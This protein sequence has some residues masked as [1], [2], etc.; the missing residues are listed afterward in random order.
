MPPVRPTE[1]LKE[2]P[3]EHPVLETLG[4]AALLALVAVAAGELPQVLGKA[5]GPALP[6]AVSLGACAAFAVARAWP[7]SRA[8]RPILGRS[9]P[10]AAAAI[11]SIALV[12]LSNVPVQRARAPFVAAALGAVSLALALFRPSQRLLGGVRTKTLRTA[13]LGALAVAAVWFGGTAIVR[14]SAAERAPALHPAA[15]F[16]L[17]LITVDTLRADA[18]GC[19]GAARETSPAIDAFA[20]EGAR[21]ARVTAQAPHTHGAMASLLTSK[22]PVAHRSVNGQ[23][24]LR[25]T[26]ETLAEHLAGLGYRTAGFL[27]NPW[28]T[29]EFGFTRGY[30]DFAPRSD[31][32]A[33]LPW[34]AA[35]ADERFFL[36][37]H[38]FDP[39]G[40]YDPKSPWIDEWSP[41]YSGPWQRVE[42]P[43][44]ERAERPGVAAEAQIDIERVRA[45]YDSEVR[46]I[47]GEIGALLASLETLGLTGET[48]VVF[49]SDHGEE[50]L[51]HGALHHSHTLYEELLHVPLVLRLPGAVPSGVVIDDVC[52]LVDVAPTALELMGLPP[53]REARGRAA[54]ALLRGGALPPKIAVAQRYNRMGRHL[55]SA[56]DGRFKLH[57]LLARTGPLPMVDWSPLQPAD[58]DWLRSNRYALFDLSR[59]P[60]ERYDIA[61]SEPEVVA[62]LASEL[63]RW[64]ELQDPGTP[65]GPGATDQNI[66]VSRAARSRLVALGYAGDVEGER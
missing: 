29:P 43:F 50:F 46:R 31:N 2:R 62:R 64:R 42:A 9:V 24:A 61:A 22:Y 20:A 17:L 52:E 63:A 51:D 36:H 57:V 16:N 53:M 30:Q 60:H 33:V 23:P 45:L 44:L 40:P 55:I 54:T 47:D 13:V 14:R 21:F 65:F 15:R 39:H 8:L 12:E 41:G 37:V 5:L 18:L 48:L 10:L 1:P 34:L 49:A 7:G 26:H 4:D 6:P 59:D 11:V 58:R 28:L 32:E 38:H 35:H 27:D 56:N 25:A 66:Q 3:P 19:Y